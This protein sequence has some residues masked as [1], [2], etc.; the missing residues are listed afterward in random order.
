MD[1]VV[2]VLHRVR[3]SDMLFILK[4][5]ASFLLTVAVYFCMKSFCSGIWLCKGA[6]VDIT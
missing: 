2:H 4:I 5:G 3:Q 6:A 1:G